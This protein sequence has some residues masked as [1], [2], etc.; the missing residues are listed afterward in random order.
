MIYIWRCTFHYYNGNKPPKYRNQNSLDLV[1]LMD[2]A[3]PKL[4]YIEEFG[5]IFSVVPC[6]IKGFSCELKF[7]ASFGNDYYLAVNKLKQSHTTCSIG[8]VFSTI[9]FD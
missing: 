8:K 9:I 4:P 6:V 7:L 5:R 3:K 1:L 2:S